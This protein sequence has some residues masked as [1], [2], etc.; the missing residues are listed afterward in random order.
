MDVLHPK[1]WDFGAALVYLSLKLLSSD[2]SK[3][4]Q[5]GGLSTVERA[6]PKV[7]FW[8]RV[9]LHALS[10]LQLGSSCL[11][12]KINITKYLWHV[13]DVRARS[14]REIYRHA[15]WMSAG[16]VTVSVLLWAVPC[17][18]M[19][20]KRETRGNRKML[21]ALQEKDCISLLALMSLTTTYEVSVYP[22]SFLTQDITQMEYHFFFST[23]YLFWA[24][25]FSWQK[26]RPWF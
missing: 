5:R 13:E 4:F 16:I 19:R 1:V 2:L 9:F 6:Y 17:D 10:L 8:A 26:K 7:C 12:W 25:Y 11:D 15:W 22:G 20:P 3:R 23:K 24:F 21:T 14:W 18:F